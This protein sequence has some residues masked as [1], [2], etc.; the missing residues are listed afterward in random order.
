MD[1]SKTWNPFTEWRHT[2][3]QWIRVNISKEDLAHF[4]SRSNAKGLWHTIM[5]LIVICATGTLAYFAFSRGLWVL[6]AFALYF[7]GTFYGFFGA[8]LHELSHN[9]VFATRWLNVGFTALFGWLFWPYN[10]HL[11]RLSHQNYHHKYTL[12]Q[13]SDGEDVPMYIEFTPKFLFTLFLNVIHLKSLAHNLWRLFTL[14]PCSKGWRGRGFKPDLWEQ[15]VMKNAGPRER[16]RVI[17]MAV[18]SVAGHV[19]F[20]AV[21]IYLGIWFLPILIT[22]APF[23]GAGFMGFM[24]GIHQHAAREANNPDFRISCGDAVL[25]PLTSLLYWRM[26]FHIEHHMFAAIP[27]YN[28]KKFSRFVADQLPPKEPAIP[29]LVKLNRKCK[30]KYGSRQNWRD[31]FGIYKGY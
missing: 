10:P 18:V 16:R 8:A 29:R 19:L 2:D 30:E 25:D 3:I 31:G 11:Y 17:R 22:F 20:V 1:N 7:Y 4:T 6:L 15:F 12:H 28:L 9:T 24:A 27:C 14:T 23:Y 13:G 5:F 21:C 26:E